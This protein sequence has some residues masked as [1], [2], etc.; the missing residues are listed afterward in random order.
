MTSR[1]LIVSLVWFLTC[2]LIAAQHPDDSE[3]VWGGAAVPHT[4]DVEGDIV[5]QPETDSNNSHSDKHDDEEEEAAAAH[6]RKV[7]G[8]SEVEPGAENATTKP[9]SLPKRPWG[10]TDETA[11][12]IPPT[13]AQSRKHHDHSHDPPDGFQLTARVYLGD[14]DKLAHFDWDA[15]GKCPIQL[16]F[17]DCGASGSTTAAV[18]TKDVYVRH[19]LAAPTIWNPRDLHPVLAIALKPF[20]MELDSGERM[21]F[22]AGD[23]ILL[24]DALRPGHRIVVSESNVLSILFVTLRY[25]HYH[26]GQQ[27][28]SLKT[29]RNSDTPCPIQDGGSKPIVPSFDGRKLRLLILGTMGLSISTL[30]ADFL[31]KTAPLW[32]AVGV[33]G[34]CFVAGSTY[35][36]TVLVDRMLNTAEVWW[37]RRQLDRRVEHAPPSQEQ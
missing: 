32:L 25:P 28:L 20:A 8:A 2:C 35:G 21:Q 12:H 7:W 30:V 18:P 23:V 14:D 29:A 9:S 27:H 19:S 37:E 5:D 11:P 15:S 13:F 36:I 10:A 31:G 4:E 16:T 3:R 17:F 22:H 26:T 1:H 34:T 6:R 33:G 24:E